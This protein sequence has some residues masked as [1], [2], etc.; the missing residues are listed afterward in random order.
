MQ[1]S[2]DPS[3]PS[4]ETGYASGRVIDAGLQA[5]MQSVYNMMSFGLVVTG[6]TAFGVANVPALF[7][8]IF[9]TTLKFVVLLAPLAIIWFG[10]TP[11]RMATKSAESLRGT[12][13]LFSV[14]MGMSMA[15]IFQIFTGQS[16]AR[17]FFITAG[18]FAATSLYGYTTKRDLTADG[19]FLFMGLIGILIASAVN[20]FMQSAVVQFVVSA[21]GVV[22]FTGLAAW[23]TQRLKLMYRDGQT[24]A[25]AKMAVMGALNLYLDFINLFQMLLHSMGQRNN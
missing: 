22:I 14:L 13:I 10:F 25:N 24:E 17:V 16:I 18:T 9:M 20:I 11:A 5:Y 2:Y 6:L 19:S 21:A 23:D 15:V 4:S 3:N 1:M 7:N 12:F 8:L